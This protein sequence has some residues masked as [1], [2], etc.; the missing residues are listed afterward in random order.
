MTLTAAELTRKSDVPKLPGFIGRLS[1]AI[2]ASAL[3]TKGI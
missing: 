2:R 1:R 3:M